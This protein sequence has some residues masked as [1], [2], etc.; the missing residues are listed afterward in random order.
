MPPAL[1]TKC[2]SNPAVALTFAARKVLREP[3][4]H[5]GLAEAA[6]EV[7][8]D[9]AARQL[10][11]SQYLQWARMGFVF[12]DLPTRLVLMG[13]LGLSVYCFQKLTA[14]PRPLLRS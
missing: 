7:I 1:V 9:A 5:D 10:Q 13:V 4:H 14:L 6:A 12:G 8:E 2:V 11:P 3:C